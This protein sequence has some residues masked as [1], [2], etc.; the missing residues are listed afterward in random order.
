MHTLVLRGLV[1]LTLLLMFTGC[2]I[3][4]SSRSEGYA[5]LN[6]LS[7]ADVDATTTLSFGPTLLSLAASFVEDDPHTRALLRDLEGVRVKIYQINGDPAVVASDLNAMS[8]ELGTQGWEPVALVREKG[9]TTHV[10]VKVA[11]TRIAGIAVMTSDGAEV[12]L[13]NVMGELRPEMFNETMAALD[14]PVPAVVSFEPDN[15]G[16]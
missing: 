15:V 9:K 14:A 4:A 8:G 5:E 10:L 16:I 7:S 1:S 12:V 13:V 11:D 3:T 2:G 6:G